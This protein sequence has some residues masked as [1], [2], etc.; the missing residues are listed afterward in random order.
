MPKSG[1]MRWNGF[2]KVENDEIACD[3]DDKGGETKEESEA[4]EEG[5]DTG[6]DGEWLTED[7]DDSKAEDWTGDSM[8]FVKGIVE[9]QRRSGYAFIK[10]L[11]KAE[12]MAVKKEKER[13]V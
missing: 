3:E 11:R 7:C 4:E 8:E 13:Y 2:H 1:H 12:E 9:V 6:D 5:G 10:R